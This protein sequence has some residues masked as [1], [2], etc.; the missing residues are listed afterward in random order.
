MAM[1]WLVAH[2]VLPTWTAR[3][4]PR[5]HATDFL[6]R[7][8]KQAQFTVFHENSSIGTIWTNYDADATS[9]QRRDTWCRWKA[10]SC[11]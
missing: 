11:G 4:P 9:I 3:Q 8:G 1:G 5:L 10:R 7:E 6:Q 2:D